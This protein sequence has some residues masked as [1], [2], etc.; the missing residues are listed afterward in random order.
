M[1]SSLKYTDLTYPDH[2]LIRTP[3]L[4]LIP[5]SST[6][7][8]TFIRKFSYPDSQFGNGGV[9][10]SEASMYLSINVASTNCKRG[11]KI[12]SIK[13]LKPSFEQSALAYKAFSESHG[14]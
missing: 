5:H 14:G 6:E 10:I 12:E 9:R 11:N 8:D 1:Q 13:P 4:E 7:S 3:V 2:S